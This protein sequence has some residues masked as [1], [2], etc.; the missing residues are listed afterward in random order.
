MEVN[1]LLTFQNWIVLACG[2]WGHSYHKDFPQPEREY[3]SVKLLHFHKID[4][5]DA[6]VVV[7]DTS[8]YYGESTGEEIAYA[9]HKNKPVFYFNGSD[10]SG[11]RLDQ[12]IPNRFSESDSIQRFRKSL[13]IVEEKSDF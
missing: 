5:S 4:I 2:S 3:A 11:S 8:G 9:L 12:P 13:K 7:S 1:R 6:I 10:F